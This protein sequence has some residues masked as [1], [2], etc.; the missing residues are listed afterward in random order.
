[1]KITARPHPQRAAAVMRN[2]NESH[3][4]GLMHGLLMEDNLFSFY[5]KPTTYVIVK[6]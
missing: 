5:C 4:S 2:N 3:R 1:M 6:Y